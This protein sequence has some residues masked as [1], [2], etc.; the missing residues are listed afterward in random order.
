MTEEDDGEAN[1]CPSWFIEV[2]K[3]WSYNSL[4]D[5]TVVRSPFSPCPIVCVCL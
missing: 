5:K 2:S 3:F 4:T 1:R